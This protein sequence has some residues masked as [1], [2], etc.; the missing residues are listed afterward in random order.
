MISCSLYRKT[1]FAPEKQQNS[2]LPPP[3][4]P[5][6]EKLKYKYSAVAPP[7]HP[8]KCEEVPVSASTKWKPTP[9]PRLSLAKKTTEKQENVNRLSV[10]SLQRP[11]GVAMRFPMSTMAVSIDVSASSVPR[12]SP[13]SKDSGLTHSGSSAITEERSFDDDFVR[14]IKRWDSRSSRSDTRSDKNTSFEIA[15]TSSKKE[16][17]LDVND[18]FF[19]CQGL[20]AELLKIERERLS[21]LR[22][23]DLD[24]LSNF[25]SITNQHAPSEVGSELSGAKRGK[26]LSPLAHFNANAK[27]VSPMEKNMRVLQWIHC[28]RKA[29]KTSNSI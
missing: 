16:E 21:S 8:R 11:V 18:D 1:F 2:P 3:R 25:T 19:D 6:P 17:Q 20:D 22:E 23:D 4:P 29:L 26:K 15:T 13:G 9:F 7:I 24:S 5:K 14:R 28:C 27:I 12:T 10:P